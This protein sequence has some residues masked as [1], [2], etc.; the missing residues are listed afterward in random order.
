MLGAGG[1]RHEGFVREMRELSVHV[2][3]SPAR[4]MRFTSY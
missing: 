4:F 2:R 1:E 3:H